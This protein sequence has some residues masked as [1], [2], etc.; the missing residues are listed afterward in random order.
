MGILDNIANLRSN[1]ARIADLKYKLL[2]RFTI[3]QLAETYD[4]YVAI[5]SQSAGDATKSPLPDDSLLGVI[6]GVKNAVQG[7]AP[8]NREKLIRGIM[9]SM[10]LE[11]LIPIAKKYKIDVSDIK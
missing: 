10:P 6:V 4:T 5:P 1:R 11:G 2:Q 7:S 3:A 8:A 9:T